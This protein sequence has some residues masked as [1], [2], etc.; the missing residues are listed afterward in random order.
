MWAVRSLLRGGGDGGGDGGRG[1]SGGA[2]L[3]LL[4]YGV[5]T[6]LTTATCM[7][8]IYLWDAALVTAEQKGV[9]LGGFYGGYLALG[10]C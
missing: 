7:R 3:L 4:V 10:K 1:L 5:E 9:L 6:V 8:E 2:E